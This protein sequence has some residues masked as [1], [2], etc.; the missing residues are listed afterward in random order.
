MGARFGVGRVLNLCRAGSWTKS[1]ELKR[2]GCPRESRLVPGC[3]EYKRV[4]GDVLN[5]RYGWC[6][7]K[8]DE[9]N[10]CGRRKEKKLARLGFRTL[11]RDNSMTGPASQD[12]R[13]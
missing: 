6:A 8:S 5:I 7:R 2:K 9:V 4:R 3:F 13:L 1:D 10:R 12:Y 11:D